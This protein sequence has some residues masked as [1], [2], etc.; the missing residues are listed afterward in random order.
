MNAIRAKLARDSGW[1][2]VEA[3][4]AV[5]VMAIMVL[6]LTIVLLAFREQLD[7][8]WAVRVMDQY[9]NDVIE[10]LTHDLRN[11]VDVS[12]TNGAGNTDRINVKYLDPIRHTILLTSQYRADLRAS[13][14]MVDGKADID[15]SFPPRF[16]GRGETYTIETFRLTPYG[17][18]IDPNEWERRDSFNRAS[19]F[20]DA[21]W[22]IRFKM[23]YTRQAI[24]LGERPWTC[25]KEYYNRVYMRNKNLVVQKG[26]TD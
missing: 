11:A 10:N 25:E 7:R 22:E 16:M 21:T 3:I 17:S 12:V 6:G 9:G 23:I 1:T 18:V 24:K 8:S 4:I 15:P 13:R 20:M 26:I 2:L 19:S 5:V 14:I